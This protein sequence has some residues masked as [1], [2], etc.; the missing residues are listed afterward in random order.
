MKTIKLS[1]NLYQIHTDVMKKCNALWNA[2]NRLKLVEI[3]ESI[4]GHTSLQ[5]GETRWNSLFYSLYQINK[6]K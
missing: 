5:P 1:Q 4:L 2:A 3:M 6:I